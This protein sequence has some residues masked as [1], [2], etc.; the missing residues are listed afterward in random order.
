MKSARLVHPFKWK[1]KT[2]GVRK[3]SLIWWVVES[4]GPLLFAVVWGVLLYCYLNPQINLG[5]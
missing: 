2:Y 3:H 4:I 1:G 5:W